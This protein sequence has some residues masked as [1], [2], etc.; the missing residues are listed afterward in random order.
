M[1]RNE[2]RHLV[3]LPVRIWG[4]SGTGQPFNVHA[5]TMDVSRYGAR[6]RNVSSLLQR[7]DVIGVQHSEHKA[8]YR[9]T[10][11]RGAGVD[12]GYTIGIHCLEYPKFIFEGSLPA[13]NAPAPPPAEAKQ[14]NCR[15]ATVRYKCTGTV[16]IRTPDSSRI[17]MW[18]R[19]SDVSRGGIYVETLSP[20]DAETPVQITI[21]VGRSQVHSR[22]VVRTSH[23]QVGMAIQ[24]TEMT[25]EDRV[26]LDSLL[27]ELE[28]SHDTPRQSRA[29]QSQQSP[30]SS[31]M[32]SPDHLPAES[33]RS[34]PDIN[35][36]IDQAQVD[37]ILQAKQMEWIV[38]QRSKSRQRTEG[39]AFLSD[40]NTERIK[41]VISSS[42]RLLEDLDHFPFVR[43][44]ELEELLDSLGDLQEKLMSFAGVEK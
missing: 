40:L 12:I 13:A 42:H 18:A 44:E 39:I 9:V 6:L 34:V 37:M 2:H 28:S 19:L 7:G 43:P 25:D 32:D 29:K 26:Q 4:I 35:S 17:Y 36:C 16:E 27:G 5:E 8:R 33:K 24:F 41:L 31:R 14:Q 11:V 10:W 21:C 22:A 15:R 1:A 30:T 38:T 3:R 20:L 23:P